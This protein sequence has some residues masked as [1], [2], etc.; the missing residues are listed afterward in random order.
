MFSKK[1]VK[2]DP[3]VINK[4]LQISK[5]VNVSIIVLFIILALLCI[6]PLLFVIMISLTSEAEINA[7][8]FKLIPDS[9]TL[10]AY[11][12][13]LTDGGNLIRAFFNSVTIT[14]LG[15]ALGLF[16]TTSFAYVLS[17]KEYKFNKFLTYV[18]LITMLFNGGMVSKYMLITRVLGW[19]N[20]LLAL[21]VP[22][23]VS[24]FNIV[25]LRTFIKTTVPGEII[26]SARIDGASEFRTFIN[27]VVPI[28]VPGIATIGLFLCLG[29]WNQWM[30]SLLY[31]DKESLYTLQ[32]LLMQIQNNI[33]YIANNADT[34]GAGFLESIQNMP[35]ESARMAIVVISTLPIACAYP[36]FQKYFISG[37]TIGA[38]KG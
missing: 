34:L 35:T 8:G 16:L 29:Y 4:F 27:I 24:A 25:I 18:M 22:A 37:L 26:E 30:P 23:A 21:I 14:V 19:K 6:V 38:V 33:D 28:C 2:D 36:F 12:Y 32:Y 20:T 17:R 15:T 3:D 31:T 13:V 5:K 1:K 7:N 10:E 11:K 9:L